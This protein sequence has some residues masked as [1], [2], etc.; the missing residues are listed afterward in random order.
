[1]EKSKIALIIG[2]A[3]LVIGMFLTQWATTSAG[4]YVTIL[5]FIVSVISVFFFIRENK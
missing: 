2:V 4:T 1:M 5:G 3:L